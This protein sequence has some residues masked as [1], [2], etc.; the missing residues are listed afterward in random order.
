MR[1]VFLIRLQFIGMVLKGVGSKNEKLQLGTDENPAT[2][3]LD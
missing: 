2:V 3:E 1:V